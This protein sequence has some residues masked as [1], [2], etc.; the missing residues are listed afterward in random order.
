MRL[1]VWDSAMLYIDLV[2][3]KNDSV[4]A[5]G[6][7]AVEILGG[8]AVDA[9]GVEAV[10]ALGGEAADAL[11]VEAVDV[12]GVGVPIAGSPGNGLHCHT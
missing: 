5:L 4:E 1:E 3:D 12:E 6:R 2:S 8:E 11:G 10:E 9:L 7:E